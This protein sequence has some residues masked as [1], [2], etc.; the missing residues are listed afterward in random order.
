MVAFEDCNLYDFAE[1]L[2]SPAKY[3][4]FQV[5]GNEFMRAMG[6]IN[7]WARGLS[8]PLFAS[9]SIGALGG[10]V[11]TIIY[12]ALLIHSRKHQRQIED[13]S[14]LWSLSS[15]LFQ[16]LGKEVLY[17]ALAS[18]MGAFITGR[19]DS[20][21]LVYLIFAGSLGPIVALSFMLGAVGLVMVLAWG[22]SKVTGK[23]GGR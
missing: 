15:S 7:I 11:L 4:L 19:H 2:A 10:A 5:I 6:S 21:H 14:T 16:N 18:I 20:N 22:G 1:V 3:A 9:A 12:T 13:F 8:T 17:S 23:L